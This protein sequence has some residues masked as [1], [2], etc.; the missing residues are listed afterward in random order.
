M[1]Q[2]ICPG[3]CSGIAVPLSEGVIQSPIVVGLAEPKSEP[4]IKI[5]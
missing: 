2:D 4:Q 1:S 3:I 5:C